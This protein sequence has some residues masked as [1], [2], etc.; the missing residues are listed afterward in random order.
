MIVEF[1][2]EIDMG[3]SSAEEHYF[4]CFLLKQNKIDKLGIIVVSID[5]QDSQYIL[6]GLHFC[7]FHL[8]C[9]VLADMGLIFFIVVGTMMCLGFRRKIMLIT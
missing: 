4:P 1:G 9:Q 5:L 2:R 7:S 6:A 3:S 8:S